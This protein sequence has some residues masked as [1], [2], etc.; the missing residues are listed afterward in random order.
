MAMNTERE[1]LSFCTPPRGKSTRFRETCNNSPG[2]VSRKLSAV[3]NLHSSARKESL[4]TPDRFIPNRIGSNQEFGS[5]EVTKSVSK[6]GKKLDFTSNT[7][8]SNDQLIKQIFCETQRLASNHR[9]LNFTP[10]KS[11]NDGK[12]CVLIYYERNNYHFSFIS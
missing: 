1:I 8:H 10:S 12:L 3:K 4:K 6:K 11:K 5:H 9:I 7:N 2:S